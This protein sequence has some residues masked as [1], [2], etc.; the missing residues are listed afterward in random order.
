MALWIHVHEKRFVSQPRH[1]GREVNAGGGFAAAALLVDDRDGPHIAP[2]VVCR[3]RSIG[4]MVNVGSAQYARISHR[5]RLRRIFSIMG[6]MMVMPRGW[7]D[8]LAQPGAW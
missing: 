3:G 2:S 4:R 7:P 8:R 6:Q 1:T 5:R